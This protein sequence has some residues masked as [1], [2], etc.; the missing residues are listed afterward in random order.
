MSKRNTKKSLK[1]NNIL[2]SFEDF[3]LEGD[4]YERSIK[5]LDKFGMNDRTK[6]PQN[7]MDQITKMGFKQIP[8]HVAGLDNV[9]HDQIYHMKSGEYESRYE[10]L[11]F[12][13]SEYPNELGLS[14]WSN[15]TSSGYIVNFEWTES[16]E[17]IRFLNEYDFNSYP[18]LIKDK[19]GHSE[20]EKTVK[21][22]FNGFNIKWSEIE[23]NF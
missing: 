13:Q 21:N 11:I 12:I 17:L 23:S 8:F 6:F 3:L 20:V 9:V 7:L 5:G 22:S 2:L 18:S 10:L 4:N 16:K 14:F 19:N 15:P 1:R